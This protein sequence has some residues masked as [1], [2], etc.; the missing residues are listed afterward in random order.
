LEIR[1]RPIRILIVEDDVVSAKSLENNLRKSGYQVIASAM[2]GDQAIQA[3]EKDQPD[4]ALMDI[5]LKGSMDGIQTA[6]QLLDRLGVPSVFISAYSED[7]TLFQ[8][9]HTA[10]YGFLVK[11]IDFQSLKNAIQ[12]ALYRHENDRRSAALN[13]IAMQVARSPNLDETLRAVLEQTLRASGMPVGWVHLDGQE[14]LHLWGKLCPEGSVRIE[15][16]PGLPIVLQ[17]NQK[18]LETCQAFSLPQMAP[19]FEVPLVWL[20]NRKEVT[21]ILAVP[22]QTKEQV[23]GVIGLL[24][25]NLPSRETQLLQWLSTVGLMLGAAV[26]NARLVQDTALI[27]ALQEFNRLRS[28]LVANVSH[29]MR[30]PLGLIKLFSTTLLRRDLTI[31]PQTTLE[32]LQDISDETDTLE[33][34]VSNLLDVS[35]FENRSLNLDF[36]PADLGVLGAKVAGEFLVSAP[37]RLRINLDFPETT[38]MA[39][40]DPVR[41]EQVFRNLLENAIKYS[42]S[43]GEITLGGQAGEHEI[44]LFV[45]DQGIGIPEEALE[46]IFE[47]FYRVESDYVR[48]VR[49]AGLGLALCRGLV[50]AHGG[51][52]WAESDPGRG[53]VFY[54]TLPNRS[55]L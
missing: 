43:G 38:L 9:I 46:R 20:A 19:A 55:N 40:I 21:Q 42:P 15:T 52:I 11:P 29:E 41:I 17:I 24:S 44:L 54:F 25:P 37:P 16:S 27:G 7:E 53:S 14:P 4:L 22:I 49:G 2:Y 6:G 34:I 1:V 36:Q 39:S 50:E 45:K 35:H 13:A 51:H 5:R 12:V 18:V 47:R 26:E 28:E 30:T 31:D 32:F 10:S 48:Q 33:Q 8:A 3:A 23:S